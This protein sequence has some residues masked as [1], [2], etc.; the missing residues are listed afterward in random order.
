MNSVRKILVPVDFSEDSANGLKYALSLAQETQAELVV[1]YV[2][3]KKEADHFFCLLASME[4]WPMPNVSTGIPI[5][6]LVREK[7][8]DLHYFIQQHARNPGAVKIRKRVV[9][10][11]KSRQILE[12]AREENVD[13]VVLAFRRQSLLRY[14]IARRRVLK[15]IPNFPCPVLLKPPVPSLA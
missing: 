13:L 2:A 4:A 5:D 11:K 8:L 1:L 9:V 12:V 15:A 14:L 10:G 3:E 7:A 6:Q